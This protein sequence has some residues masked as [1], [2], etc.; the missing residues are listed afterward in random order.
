MAALAITV[1]QNGSGD[2]ATVQEAIDAIPLGNTRR[3]VIRIAPGIYKQ[4]LYV[5]KTKNLITFSGLRPEDTVL[6]YDN[7]AANI[8]H[9]HQVT[10]FSF[11]CITIVFDRLIVL[12]YEQA[13]RVI[14]TGT[15][16]CASTIV[17]GEDFIAENITFE[18]SAPEVFFF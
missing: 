17:E 4:P 1:A 2:Y 10:E 6:C 14:G 7:T 16:G 15:F 5:P 3:T 11:C 18:N 12:F 9:H 13:S 8:H